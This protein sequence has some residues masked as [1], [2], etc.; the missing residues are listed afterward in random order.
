MQANNQSKIESAKTS[1]LSQRQSKYWRAAITGCGCIAPIHVQS[2]ARLTHVNLEA[3]ADVLPQAAS[4]MAAFW[5]AQTEGRGRQ[6]SC[7]PSTFTDL[8]ACLNTIQPDVMHICTPHYLHAGQAAE[9][10]RQGAHVLLEK[11]AGISLDDIKLLQQ[12]A[13]DSG[14]Q[15]GLCFQNRYNKGS[16]QAWLFMRSGI[17]GP[18]QAARA[19]L[20]WHRD[21]AYYNQADWRGRWATEGGGVMINQAIHTL[22]LLIWLAGRPVSVSGSYAKRQPDL[23]IEVEDTAECMMMLENGAN[24]SF[25]ATNAFARD[26]Q[27]VVDFYTEKGQ[28][29]LNGDKLHLSEDGSEWLSAEAFMAKLD[30]AENRL[31]GQLESMTPADKH[32]FSIWQQ[33]GKSD[34]KLTEGPAAEK[35]YWGQGHARLIESFYAHLN[36]WQPGKPTFPIGLEQ[37]CLSLKTLLALYESHRQQTNI[38]IK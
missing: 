27:P 8:T 30:E 35:S 19:Q 6:I 13:T 11:P 4:Q 25:Y 12:A 37:G 23:S 31:I 17:L 28:L 1:E 32:W 36:N 34:Q 9:A 10:M 24:A 29:L 22:D 14:R 5:L 7:A 26:A 2:I 21:Q 15:I 38:M 20:T 16:L 3:V 33:Y 18:V